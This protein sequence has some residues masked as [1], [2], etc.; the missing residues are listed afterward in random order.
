MPRVGHLPTEASRQSHFG[1]RDCRGG[2]LFDGRGIGEAFW[3]RGR[4]FFS[5]LA[6]GRCGAGVRSA[7]W[8]AGVAGNFSTAFFQQPW[9]GESVDLHDSGSGGNDSGRGGR[10][11]S[12]DEVAV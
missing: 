1:Q 6:S 9:S 12:V 8:S 2:G 11:C 3:K 7:A 4:G 10:R 5:D